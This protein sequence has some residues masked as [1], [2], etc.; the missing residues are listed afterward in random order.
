MEFN[1]A[2]EFVNNGIPVTR[3]AWD[4]TKR[5]IYLKDISGSKRLF[6]RY[7]SGGEREA[8]PSLATEDLF[9]TDWIPVLPKFVYVCYEE[10]YGEIASE[11][12]SCEICK[13]FTDIAKAEQW[14]LHEIH[15]GKKDGYVVDGEIDEE[16]ESTPSSCIRDI[17][18][19]SLV[20]KRGIASVTMYFQEQDNWK[21]YYDLVIERK[22]INEE[23]F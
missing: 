19:K 12:G 21:M 11:N 13:V 14:L 5:E 2:L 8:L 6:V 7:P 17:V 15:M 3:E 23:V 22:D 20:S 1:K 18:H 16:V 4:V 10:N 9:A